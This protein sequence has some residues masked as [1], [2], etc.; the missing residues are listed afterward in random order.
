MVSTIYSYFEASE[1]DVMQEDEKGMK[2]DE[3]V[4]HIGRQ[5][6]QHRNLATSR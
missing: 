6:R 4:W 2:K 3:G 5:L 1:R